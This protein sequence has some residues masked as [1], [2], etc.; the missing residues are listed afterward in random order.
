MSAK[1]K[2][3]L[4]IA[5]GLAVVV[6]VALYF[7]VLRKP[8]GEE[9]TAAETSA[10]TKETT[11][12][13]KTKARPG[14]G[15][16]GIAARPGAPGALA[17]AGGPKPGAPAGPAAAPAEP[18]RVD[19]FAPLFPPP[20]K[21]PPPPPPPPPPAVVQVGIPP[22]I[23]QLPP[24]AVPRPPEER[25]RMAG[26]L[27]NDRVYAIIETENTV[28]VVQPG[29][30]VDGG[31]VRSISPEA[32]MLATTGG[33]EVEVPLRNRTGPAPSVVRTAT[34]PGRPGLPGPAAPQAY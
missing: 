27:W 14:A 23:A 6:L 15:A 26:V 2:Q 16:V 25:R 21:P 19:P 11:A 18:Y 4:G 5:I 20:P 33:Q 24:E 34:P 10:A 28:A 31:T 9:T 17:A 13:S 32:L 30:T 12:A 22:V 1:D 7:L 8:K 3:R 29:D